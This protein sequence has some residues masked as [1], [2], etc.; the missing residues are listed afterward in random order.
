MAAITFA[1]GHSG[2]FGRTLLR[3]PPSVFFLFVFPPGPMQVNGLTPLRSCGERVEASAVSFLSL[4]R[5]CSC[6]ARRPRGP[7]IGL[8]HLVISAYIGPANQPACFVSL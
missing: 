8:L 4:I 6:R 2:L 7:E 3:G 1:F 5:I